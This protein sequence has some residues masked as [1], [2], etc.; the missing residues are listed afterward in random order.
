MEHQ[1]LIDARK[2]KGYTQEKMAAIIA[3]EQTTYSRK[4]RGKSPVSNE[5]WS[6]FAKAL[7]VDID[8]IKDENFTVAQ[9]NDNCT[10]NES[11]I[12]GIQY[13]NIP[14]NVFD[15]IIKYNTKLEEENKILKDDIAF[16]KNKS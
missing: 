15:I 11:S 10:F 12:I 3:M 1:K 13:V 5:E 8:K 9:K 4:E 14:Q 7:D 6:R 2:A 16:L